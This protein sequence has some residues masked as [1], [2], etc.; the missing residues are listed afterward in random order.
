MGAS[1]DGFVNCKCCG[2]GDI[3]VKCPFCVKDGLLWKRTSRIYI[4]KNYEMWEFK[5]THA[6]YFQVQ[7]QI[8]ACELEYC[9]FEVW[10]EKENV[11]D[12]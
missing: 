1:P 5:R 4:E 11:V 3:E 2:K 12:R 10:T 9:D 8:V 7:L 6:Y